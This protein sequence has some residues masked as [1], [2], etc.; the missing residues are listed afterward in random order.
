MDDDLDDAVPAALT[1]PLLRDLDSIEQDLLAAIWDPIEREVAPWPVWDYV[2]RTLYRTPL[3]TADAGAVLASLPTT[4]VP[5]LGS[6]FGVTYGLVWR[7]GQGLG[8]AREESEQGPTRRIGTRRAASEEDRDRRAPEGLLDVRAVLG[9]RA[10]EDRHAVERDAVAR[11][12]GLHA[13]RDLDALAGLAGPGRERDAL[14]ELDRGRLPGL[15]E[16]RPQ[17][18]ER[19]PSRRRLECTSSS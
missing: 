3:A 7:S 13:P 9:G 10:Q 6:V 17:R 14:V 4:S 5:I 16:M 1:N 11:G 2:S 15:E 12:G 8:P 18:V 19:R